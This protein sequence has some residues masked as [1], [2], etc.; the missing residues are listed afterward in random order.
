MIVHM[1]RVMAV[2]VAGV[3]TVAAAAE[4]VLAE[5]A[6]TSRSQRFRRIL[7]HW[8]H[9]TRLPLILQEEMVERMAS[10]DIPGREVWAVNMVIVPAGPVVAN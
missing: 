10:K 3:E 9:T 7:Y 5:T 4:A 8:L 1:G 6:L 2:M